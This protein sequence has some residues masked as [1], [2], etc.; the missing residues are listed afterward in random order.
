LV[1]G[2]DFDQSNANVGSLQVV[3]TNRFRVK[4]VE[5]IG[6]Q[7]GAV[8]TVRVM[9]TNEDGVG[10]VERLRLPDGSDDQNNNFGMRVGTTG[11][12]TNDGQVTVR[13]CHIKGFWDNGLY[14]RDGQ[15]IVEGGLYKNC[16]ISCVRV[17][18]DGSAV[19]DCE[20]VFDADPFASAPTYRA[21]RV[22][23]P[24]NARVENVDVTLDG[25]ADSKAQDV[26]QHHET[27]GKAVYDNVH[28]DLGDTS[29]EAFEVQAYS[30]SDD[31][32]GVTY[33][34]CSA[35]GTADAADS[36]DT[37]R[38]ARARCTFL[39]FEAEVVS[40]TGSP[41]NILRVVDGDHLTIIGGRFKADRRPIYIGAGSS[42][43]TEPTVIG[44]Y[45]ENT[46]LSGTPDIRVQNA[47]DA[48]VSAVRLGGSGIV[49]V[50]A[51]ATETNLV[52]MPWLDSGNV[53]DSGTRTRHEGVIGGGP[54]GGVDLGSVNGQ[55]DG[56]EAISDGTNALA[57]AGDKGRWDDGN[58]QWNVFNADT[59]I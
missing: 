57:S 48:H 36:G 55:F 13:D 46:T 12:V 29:A 22:R 49:Q 27:S 6:E 44:A 30:G 40:G 24:Q 53:D 16:S 19:R 58:T 25:I 26:V 42:T 7:T 18:G 35:V 1:E 56:D 14:G 33:I 9:C 20:I 47:I 15:V 50:D 4:D 52:D 5:V 31:E 39:G 3:A 51:E 34:N 8:P 43:I 41:R 37:V 17:Q 32:Y 45:C 28:V 59:T 21:V 11:P 10:V 38:V 54:L 23:G 2:L